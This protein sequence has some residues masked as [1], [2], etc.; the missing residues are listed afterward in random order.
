MTHASAA[1]GRQAVT[2]SMGVWEGIAVAPLMLLS[3]IFVTLM[4][5]VTIIALPARLLLRESSDAYCDF[6]IGLV[7]FAA[8]N[9][10]ILPPV[11]IYTLWT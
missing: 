4:L 6:I 8:L 11:L 5:P 2:R 1:I 7:A 9:A 3:L 10:I